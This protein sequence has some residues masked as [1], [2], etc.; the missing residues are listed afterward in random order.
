MY[1]K[2]QQLIFDNSGLY[3]NNVILVWNFTSISKIMFI[4]NDRNKIILF[5]QINYLHC[6]LELTKQFL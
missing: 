5:Y 3:L 6:I 4:L 1:R 2:F